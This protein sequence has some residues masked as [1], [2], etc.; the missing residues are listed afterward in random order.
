MLE[1]NLNIVTFFIGI[2]LLLFQNHLDLFLHQ[3]YLY[4]QLF[5]NIRSIENFY[6]VFQLLNPEKCIF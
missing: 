5:L 4:L 1:E 6:D 2:V 3:G